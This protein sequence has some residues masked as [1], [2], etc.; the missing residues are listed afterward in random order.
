MSTRAHPDPGVLFWT[1]E[2]GLNW[3]HTSGVP[4]CMPIMENLRGSL[5]SYLLVYAHFQ[6]Y[7]V[8]TPI[9]EEYRTMN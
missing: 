9:A 8:I 2:Q 5:A 3:Q 6:K 4:A 1:I 7:L